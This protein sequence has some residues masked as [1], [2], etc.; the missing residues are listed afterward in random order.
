MRSFRSSPP[1]VELGGC[2]TVIAT[3]L[4]LVGA[5]AGKGAAKII[6]DGECAPCLLRLLDSTTGESRK[7]DVAWL[8]ELAL[9]LCGC[10]PGGGRSKGRWNLECFAT[11]G[12]RPRLSGRRAFGRTTGDGAMYCDDDPGTTRESNR[13]LSFESLCWPRRGREVSVSCGRLVCDVGRDFCVFPCV[14]CDD[15]G[16]NKIRMAVTM[17]STNEGTA[18]KSVKP[19][20]PRRRTHVGCDASQLSP[21]MGC[22]AS[23]LSSNV[24]CE[25]R[26]MAQSVI[27]SAISSGSRIAMRKNRG[28]L[29]KTSAAVLR[30]IE[31]QMPERHAQATCVSTA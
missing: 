22:A 3:A 21:S 16:W 27:M 28:Q 31:A 9:R 14:R 26:V 5:D 29:E 18:S 10:E 19:A 15:G 23:S 12:A 8:C 4:L 7:R 20:Y 6:G 30:V 24:T 17:D 2:V 13:E 25:T 1:G 11:A